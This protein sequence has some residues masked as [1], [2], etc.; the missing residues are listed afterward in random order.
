MQ[1]L[2]STDPTRETCPTKIMQ[3]TRLPPGKMSSIVQIR[4]VSA[5]NDLDH[6]VK[7]DDVS[8][9]FTF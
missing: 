5:L 6:E 1:D 3:V 4:D 7:I 9:V 8:E 2:C